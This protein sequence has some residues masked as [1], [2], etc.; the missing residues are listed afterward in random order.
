MVVP[1]EPLGPVKGRAHG[2]YRSPHQCSYHTCGGMVAAA[3]SQYCK[4]LHWQLAV[5]PELVQRYKA[6]GA[7]EHPRPI[8]NHWSVFWP[9]A[10]NP[11]TLGTNTH[12]HTH[13]V[14]QILV[15]VHCHVAWAN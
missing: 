3:C 5:A 2:L 4:I 8:W 13:T 1:V 15:E 10:H 14:V 7:L 6:E 12:T 11:G 9:S